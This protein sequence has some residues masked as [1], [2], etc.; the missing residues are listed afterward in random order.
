MVIV[1]IIQTFARRTDSSRTHN[2]LIDGDLR[3]KGA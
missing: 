2:C 1:T 3:V